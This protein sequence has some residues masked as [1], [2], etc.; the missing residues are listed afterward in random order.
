LPLDLPGRLIE[1]TKA[2]KHSMGLAFF[3]SFWAGS[4]PFDLL[5]VSVLYCYPPYPRVVSFNHPSFILQK[6]S[7]FFAAGQ[8]LVDM[9]E[10]N[11]PSSVM[12]NF[13]KNILC[14][15]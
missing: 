13:Q 4:V 14:A 12:V 2:L 7:W 11:S 10:T 15:K 5:K 1:S 6:K 8:R 3:S 9:P